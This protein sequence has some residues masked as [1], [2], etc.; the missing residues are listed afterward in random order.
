MP[1]LLVSLG[2]ETLLEAQLKHANEIADKTYIVCNSKHADMIDAIVKLKTNVN[3]KYIIYN[4]ADG[5]ANTVRTALDEV[6]NGDG[7][8]LVIWSDI[9][10][11]NADNELTLQPL[12]KILQNKSTRQQTTVSIVLDSNARHRFAFDSGFIIHDYGQH[13]E[14]AG[15]YIIYNV[16]EFAKVADKYNDGAYKEN[17]DFVELLQNI[18]LND[19]INL[20]G[21]TGFDFIDIGDR[22]KYEEFMSNVSLKQRFFNN[23]EFREKTVFKS[24]NCEKGRNIMAHEIAHYEFSEKH[25]SGYYAHATFL[26]GAIMMDRLSKTVHEHLVD[27]GYDT[28]SCKLMYDNFVKFMQPMHDIKFD[29]DTEIM[30]DACIDEYI[31][32]LYDRYI[33][34]Q[35][36]AEIAENMTACTKVVDI[37]ARLNAYFSNIN[38]GVALIHGD[39]N[40][41]NVMLDDDGQF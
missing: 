20:I 33:T 1:K 25:I 27:N 18:R 16:N 2:Q 11:K 8:A 35:P 6:D 37:I 40:T 34:M 15:A 9:C 10:L 29:I 32:T 30:H 17:K 22:S 19:K 28:A 26:D 31:T 36:F 21:E 39:T 14:I 41:S 3:P 13:G 12:V 7:S 24:A 23:I 38:V 5:T 4:K